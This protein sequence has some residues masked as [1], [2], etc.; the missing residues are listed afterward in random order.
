MVDILFSKSS[1]VIGHWPDRLSFV[2]KLANDG[3]PTTNDRFLVPPYRRLIQIDV[4]L[5]RLQIFFDSPWPQLTSEAGLLVATPR[6]FDICW[7]HVID[8]DD[9]GTK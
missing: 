3:R 9:P 5:L 8:P 6:R 7:L 1:L 4:H 2:I